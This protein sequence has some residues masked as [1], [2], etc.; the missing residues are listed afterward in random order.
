MKLSVFYLFQEQLLTLLSTQHHTPA[1]H[2]YLKIY[3]HH[4]HGVVKHGAA[5]ANENPQEHRDEDVDQ[6]S[7]HFVFFLFRRDYELLP[8]A[9]LNG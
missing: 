2:F 7:P 8:R 6:E 3:L 4:V 9:G 1:N 5:N